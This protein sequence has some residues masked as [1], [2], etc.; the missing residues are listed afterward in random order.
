MSWAVSDYGY[1]EIP[2]V[3][4]EIEYNIERAL[5]YINQARAAV[6]EEN[7]EKAHEKLELA[8]YYLGVN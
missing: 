7:Y 4:S 2:S 6:Q 3:Q 5:K 8:E 1:E